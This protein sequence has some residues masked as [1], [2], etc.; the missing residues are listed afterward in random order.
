MHKPARLFAFAV[1]LGY[2]AAPVCAQEPRQA[3]RVISMNLCTDQLAMLIAAPGQVHSVSW[4]AADPDASALAADANSLALNHGLAEEIFLMQPDLVLSGAYTTRATVDL[5]RKLGVRVEE[6]APE[7]SLADIRHNI[8]KMGEILNQPV[9]AGEVLAIFDAGVAQAST[10]VRQGKTAATY[11]ANSYTAGSGTLV[12]S[13]ITASGLENIAA[14][15]GFVGT[16]RLPLEVLLLAAPDVLVD[17]EDRPS[18]P[19]LAQENFI[20]P[21]YLQLAGKSARAVVPSKYTICGGPFTVEAIRLLR[22]AAAR[23]DSSQ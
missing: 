21:A 6:F 8:V 7:A 16:V 18:K 15:L 9:R 1:T 5:L 22:A 20:H 2:L 12:D 13:L 4:L 23:A 14:R 3:G 19:A 17:T 11:F 10:S